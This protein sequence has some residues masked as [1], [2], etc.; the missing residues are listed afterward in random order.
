M[1]ANPVWLLGAAPL[2]LWPAVLNGYPLV[3]ADTGTY[4]SQ[5]VNH[6]LGWDRPPFYSL[7]LLPLHMKITTWPA[8]AVQALLACWVISIVGR[9]LVRGWPDWMIVPVAA[10][11]AC[12]TPLPWT[13]S[14][15]S[16]D[17]LTPLMVLGLA[18]LLLV[19]DRLARWEQFG[20]IATT[21]LGV[22]AHLSNLPIA[23][24]LLCILLPVRPSLAPLAGPALGVVALVSVNL[25]AGRGFAIA[26]YGNVFFLARVIADGPGRDIMRADCPL[27]AW[28][29]CPY[30][31]ELPDTADDFLWA[32][33]SPLYAAGG[34]K[35][36]STEA[37]AII[38]AAMSAEPFR[39]A[40]A[41]AANGGEQFWRFAT[42]DGLR[43]WPRE[44]TPW[45]VRDF[46]RAEV[47]RYMAAR[48]T[49]GLPLVPGWMQRLHLAV[50]I[51]SIL[52]C[53]VLLV[54]PNCRGSPRSGLLVAALLGIVGNAIVCGGLSGPHDRYQ[55]RV[56]WLPEL[57][58]GL[59]VA[60]RI[61]G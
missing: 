7:F 22:A 56:M 11:M 16:P 54:A 57:V 49:R 31:D 3:F 38:V 61:R 58:A 52:M 15:L 17:F 4:V 28:R 10:A 8:I 29:L 13:V 33:N 48:Q 44:V 18:L 37:D 35:Q 25:I 40:A 27:S 32:Q 26:P 47:A 5:A 36:V 55:S 9:V 30:T 1:R 19:P 43:P 21:A 60:S 51:S 45:I 24:I 41:F 50:S 39:E 46:P 59:A 53:L 2:L 14:E 6:Y 12:L 34:P 42:G 20:L 23:A